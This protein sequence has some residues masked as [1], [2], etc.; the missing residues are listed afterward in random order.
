MI[1]TRQTREAGFTDTVDDAHRYLDAI[2][3]PSADN[4]RAIYL[5]TGKDVVEYLDRRSE[6]K[7]SA[8]TR[9]PD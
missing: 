8:Y 5:E 6:V 9:H 2:I 7:F 1:G 4:R 3:G